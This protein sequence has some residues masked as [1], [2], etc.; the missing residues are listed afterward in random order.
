MTLQ[1]I[2]S[3]EIRVTLN[4]RTGCQEFVENAFRLR[5]YNTRREQRGEDQQT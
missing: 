5:P 1:A 2:F 3:L 4:E